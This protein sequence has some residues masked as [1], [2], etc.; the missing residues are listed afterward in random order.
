MIYSSDPDQAQSHMR[1]QGHTHTPH[2]HTCALTATWRCKHHMHTLA[3]VCMDVYRDMHKHTHIYPGY[4]DIVIT[5]Q[6]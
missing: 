6:P 4:T 5:A 3:H 1:E 2:S